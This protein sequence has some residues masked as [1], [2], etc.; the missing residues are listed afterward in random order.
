MGL[1]RRVSLVALLVT[2]GLFVIEMVL[3]SQLADEKLNAETVGVVFVAK[4]IVASLWLACVSHD[5]A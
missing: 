4:F 5:D 1:L 3:L 2:S